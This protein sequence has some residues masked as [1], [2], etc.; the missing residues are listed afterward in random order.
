MIPCACLPIEH[1]KRFLGDWLWCG[2]GMIP[3]TTPMI[4]KGSIYKW[5]WLVVISAEVTAISALS[6]SLTSRNYM[7]PFS[8][9]LSKLRMPLSRSSTI[10][11]VKRIFPLSRISKGRTNLPESVL[12]MISP[13]SSSFPFIMATFTNFSTSPLLLSNLILSINLVL[14]V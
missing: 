6:S 8:T 1:W 10:L 7:T 12:I 13:Y 4:V 14:N 11:W 9:R 5:V 3:A 2:Y